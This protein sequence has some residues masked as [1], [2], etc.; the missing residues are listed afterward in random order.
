[1]TLQEIRREGIKV[2]A[3]HLGPVNM[4]RFLLQY[5]EGS[6]DYTQER[7]RWLNGLTIQ[8]IVEAIYQQ[9]KKAE[10]EK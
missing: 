1:M 4:A 10:S 8:Q 7:L 6:G 3:R 9:R 5:G 2:L